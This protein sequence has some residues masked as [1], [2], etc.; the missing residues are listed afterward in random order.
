MRIRDIASQKMHLGNELRISQLEVASLRAGIV[1]N[2]GFYG[3]PAANEFLR[4]VRADEAPRS[5]NQ[6]G[7]SLPI[8]SRSSASIH[9]RKGEIL[10]G[11][12]TTYVPTDCGV[13]IRTAFGT[14]AMVTGVVERGSPSP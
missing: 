9:T 8:H 6:Y 11:G 13:I 14:T 10:E 3:C 2:H 7:L 12:L 5:G 1:M 4:Q